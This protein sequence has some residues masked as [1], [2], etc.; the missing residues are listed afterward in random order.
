MI[1]RG[2]HLQ[3]IREGGLRLRARDHVTTARVRA[4]DDPRDLGAQDLVIVA[5]KATA[6]GAVADT[7]APLLDDGTRA[8]FPQNG[9]AWWYPHGLP[10]GLPRPP[11]APIFTLGEKFLRLMDV[12]RIAGG[13]IYSANL[14]E[15]PGVVVN[16]SPEDNRLVLAAV[17]GNEDDGIRAMRR[18][19]EEAGIGSRRID[20][21]RDAMWRK[22]LANVTGSIIALVSGA[23]S[24]ACRDHAGLRE[25]FHRAVAE[26]RA[27]AAAHGYP[28]TGMINSHQMLDR[29]LDHKPSILQDYEQGR[30]MEVGEI[31]LAPLAF[32]RAAGVATPTLDTLG[33]VAVRLA[34]GRSLFNLAD[35]DGVALWQATPAPVAMTRAPAT[36]G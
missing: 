23:T 25:V 6:L 9:M 28:M 21:L 33:A 15:S 10:A 1:A 29:L 16:R 8:L 7:I 18:I 27:T 36:A 4:S 35:W 31:I 24:G 17:N 19:L 26:C 14:V 3:A 30:P 20:D 34:A 22:L 32:A 2:A 13:L 5:T 11:A 12:G